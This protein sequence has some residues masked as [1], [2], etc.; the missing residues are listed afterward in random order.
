M[1]PKGTRRTSRATNGAGATPAPSSAPAHKRIVSETGELPSAKR[2][3]A[4]ATLNAPPQPIP[5]LHVSDV[6]QDR[7][8]LLTMGLLFDTQRTILI[9][10]HAVDDAVVPRKLF[11]W[12]TGEAG[13]L[14]LGEPDDDNINKLTKAKPFG[15]KALSQQTD[16]GE[17]GVGGAEA[18][19]AGGMH[20]LLVDANGQVFSCGSDDHGTL[21]RSHRD[22]DMTEEED[23][24]VLRATDSVAPPGCPPATADTAPRFRAT[25]IAASDGCSGALD[26]TGALVAWGH[27]KDGEGKVCFS[28]SDANGAP[29]EQWCPTTLPGLDS[30]RFAAVA[31]GENHMLALTLDG[32]VYSWGLNNAS[33]LGRFANLYHVRAQ[34]T[35][36]DPPA[37]MHLTPTTIP[38]LKNIVHIACGLNTSFAVDADGRV[39]AWGLNTRGQT[40]TGLKKDRVTRPTRVK[41]LE[42][43]HQNGASVI[44]IAGGEFH[45]VFLMSTGAV[46]VCG[47]G[48]EG[49]LGLPADHEAM[50]ASTAPLLRTPVAV[51]MPAPPSHAAK[52][53]VRADGQTRVIGI[54]AGMRFSFALAADGTL[55]SWGTTSDEAM[56]QPAA[57]W[58]GDQSKPT[59]TAVPMPGEPGAWRIVSVATAGQHSL[60]L[61]AR[62]P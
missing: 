36:R 61:A 22:T 48:D 15:N 47:D 31:C 50:A 40:G 9:P 60:A 21:G 51:P 49:K 32:R 24:Y 37:S 45:S 29:R 41:T 25:R 2:A 54:A 23:F 44:Q 18:V 20:T 58:G 27:F 16:A 12:G 52:S 13:Q 42:P 55:Y 33:Q 56:G 8:G 19:A 10:K 1:P 6:E 30:E 59:P 43:T 4:A 28:D 39:F 62:A 46:W 34:Y 7:A 3:R 35:T 11:V 17:L 26:D 5:A 57:T 53:S 38:E 14:S